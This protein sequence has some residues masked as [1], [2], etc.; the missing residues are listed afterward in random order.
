MKESINGNAKMDKMRFENRLGSEQS[1]AEKIFRKRFL[2]YKKLVDEVGEEA[3]FEKMMT[4]Y[5]EQQKDLMGTFIEQNTIANGFRQSVPIFHLMGFRADFLDISEN[6]S[7][8][9]LEIQYVCPVLS[10]AKEYGFA[11]PCRVVCEMSQEA[12][13]RAFPEIKA[14]ILSKISEGEC[15]CVFK[16]ERPMRKAIEPATKTPNIFIELL[17]LLMLTPKSLNVGAK[18]IAKRLLG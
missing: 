4:N 2:K 10:L 7:D 16:Y 6:G 3:A 1:K 15:V 12:A 11:T 18:M 17:Q 9:A 5:P 13:R 14:N 8:A